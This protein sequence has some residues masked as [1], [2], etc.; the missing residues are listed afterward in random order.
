M[1]SEAVT[2]ECEGQSTPN[3]RAARSHR[4]VHGFPDDRSL[5]D[6]CADPARE[7]AERSAVR[8][9]HDAQATEL[10]PVVTTS[11]QRESSAIKDE[12][13]PMLAAHH[14]ETAVF[15]EEFPLAPN[16]A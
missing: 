15:A 9:V 7:D 8:R 4:G 14:A 16:L 12:I 3:R 6:L 13:A 10:T 2:R 11:Y 1:E 5:A